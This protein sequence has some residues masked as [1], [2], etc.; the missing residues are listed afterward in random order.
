VVQCGGEV[1][2]SLGKSMSDINLGMLYLAREVLQQNRA[3]GMANL[4]ITPEVAN[5]LLALSAEE[6]HRLAHTPMLLVGLRW[7]G[8]S[9]WACLRQ[10]A[11]GSAAALPRAVLL[12]EGELDHVH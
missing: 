10:Y 5:T 8:S 7:R 4:G 3:L 12:G 1:V 11:M 2:S 9:V 6:L